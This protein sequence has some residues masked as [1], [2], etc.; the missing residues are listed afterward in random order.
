MLTQKQRETIIRMIGNIEGMLIHGC[1]YEYD[2]MVAL[3]TPIRDRLQKIINDDDEE[4]RCVN[5]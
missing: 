2:E 4:P 5:R 3:L 1:S